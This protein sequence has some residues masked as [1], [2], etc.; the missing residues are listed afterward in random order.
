[1]VFDAFAFAYM[2]DGRIVVTFPGNLVVNYMLVSRRPLD[3]KCHR[4]S[5]KKRRQ[6]SVG[7]ASWPWTATAAAGAPD[8]MLGL[9]R[10][11]N[12]DPRHNCHP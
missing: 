3:K 1:M 4:P 9:A 8:S 11:H 5:P 7:T 10:S 2:S 12:R 6:S